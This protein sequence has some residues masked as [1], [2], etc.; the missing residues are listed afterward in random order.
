MLGIL[1]TIVSK[2]NGQ[3]FQR[4]ASSAAPGRNL[5]TCRTPQLES[6]PNETVSRATEQ[7]L[8]RGAGQ[9]AP[10]GTGQTAP[11]GNS[12][13]NQN[14]GVG[15]GNRGHM[16]PDRSRVRNILF[17]LRLLINFLCDFQP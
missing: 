8:P 7:N 15:E 14:N 5:M 12:C 2:T 6:A 3:T 10:R 4:P 11:R 17:P 9:S 13:R 1:D 16:Y